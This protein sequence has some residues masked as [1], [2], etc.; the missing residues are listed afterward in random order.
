M[1]RYPW[2]GKA[3]AGLVALVLGVWLVPPLLEQET[4]EAS[5]V[6]DEVG[7]LVEQGHVRFADVPVGTIDRVRLTDDHRA[8]VTLL[9][10]ADA[11]LPADAV[12]VLRMTSLLGERYVDLVADAEEGV[13]V[14]PGATLPGYYESDIELLVD[15]GSDLL[16]A[17]SADQVARTIEVGARTLDGR[18]DLLGTLVEDLGDYLGELERGRGELTRFIDASE[19]L[20]A[21]LAPDAERNAA[22]LEDLAELSA[23][24]ADEEERLVAALDDLSGTAEVGARIVGDNRQSL[25]DLLE[26]V[27]RFSA[28]VLRIDQALEN[29]LL[30]LPR[31]NIHVPGGVVAEFTQVLN[32]FTVCGYN[33][34]PDNPANACDPPN[35]GVPNDPAPGYEVD[36]CILYHVNCAG[37]PEGIVPYRGD[38][39]AERT[40]SEERQRKIDQ[41]R[42]SVDYRREPRQPAPEGLR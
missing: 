26:R 4:I 29:L 13:P 37:Y 34:E 12:A 16:G 40:T 3:V 20:A 28:E 32:D 10:D 17:M 36:E 23:V 2:L 9:I 21:T 22:A 18:G 27:S 41:A 25:D 7:D 30:W 31:H 6:F 24:L 42:D 35:P 39:E 5:V 38:I 33:D 8:E 1:V 14:E 11:T 19:G 15:A